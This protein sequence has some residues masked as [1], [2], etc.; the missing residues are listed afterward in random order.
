MRGREERPA[1]NQMHVSFHRACCLIS[2]MQHAP[3][4]GGIW[5]LHGAGSSGRLGRV[6]GR[7]QTTPG[8]PHASLDTTVIDLGNS[9]CSQGDRGWCSFSLRLPNFKAVLKDKQ[10]RGAVGGETFVNWEC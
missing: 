10:L 9:M 3:P 5:P 2:N 6:P 1:I 8:A 4:P 7:C